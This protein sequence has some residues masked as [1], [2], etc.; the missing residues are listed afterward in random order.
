MIF[1]LQTTFLTQK[2]FVFEQK[3]FYIYPKLKP[4]QRFG[5]WFSIKGHNQQ[6]IFQMHIKQFV[7]N[8]GW[9]QAI[10]NISSNTI[11]F[12]YETNN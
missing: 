7:L 11:L 2:I 8:V 12:Q 3:R 9:N 4:K 1:C 5:H 6:I 10:L